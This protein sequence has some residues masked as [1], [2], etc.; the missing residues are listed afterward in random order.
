[1]EMGL[2]IKT[3]ISLHIS[4]I[5]L[6]TW[7]KWFAIG[8]EKYQKTEYSQ[9]KCFLFIL[10]EAETHTIPKT[11]YMGIMNL[12]SIGKVWENTNIPRIWVSYILCTP[13]FHL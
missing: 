3:F 10:Q 5:V 1:M 4:S 7:G 6:K 11:Q 13:L 9:V 2:K 12:L 8:Q